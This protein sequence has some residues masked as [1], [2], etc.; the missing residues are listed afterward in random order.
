MNLFALGVFRPDEAP[1]GLSIVRLR[2]SEPTA[3]FSIRNSLSE[4]RS[5]CSGASWG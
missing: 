1:N 2:P 3:S 4:C 5:S